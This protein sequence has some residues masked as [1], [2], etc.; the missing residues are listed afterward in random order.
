MARSILM[1]VM[2]ILTLPGLSVDG[3]R[4]MPV[5]TPARR[6]AAVAAAAVP[7]SQGFQNPRPCW[8]MAA[9]AEMCCGAGEGKG[10]DCGGQTELLDGRGGS[11][12]WPASA[13]APKAWHPT[14]MLSLVAAA[15]IACQPVA[16]AAAGGGTSHR[17][18]AAVE[19]TLVERTLVQAWP[20][21]QL[22]FTDDDVDELQDGEL[23][24]Q[25]AKL[26]FADDEQGMAA[27]SGEGEHEHQGGMIEN[28]EPEIRVRG[29]ARTLLF[30]SSRVQV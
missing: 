2:V 15:G 22:A 11:R 29:T 24:G 12:G 18:G 6:A 9:A 30:F 17:Q 21:W 3:L 14:R 20:R 25:S 10:R 5:A 13:S 23:D 1:T 28:K 26:A 19:R 16:A 4:T 27:V 8:A 7:R